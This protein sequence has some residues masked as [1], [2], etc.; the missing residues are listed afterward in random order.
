MA[1]SEES[2]PQTAFLR[3]EIPAIEWNRSPKERVVSMKKA[4]GILAF[5][6]LAVFLGLGGYTAWLFKARAQGHGAGGPPGMMGGIGPMPVVAADVVFVPMAD[7]IEAVGTASADKSATLTATVTEAVVATRFEEGQPVTAGQVMIQLDDAEEQATFE[8]ARKAY[9]RYAAL[10]K[11]SA[12]SVARRDQE[13]ARMDVAQ[14]RARDRQIVAPF[15]GVAGLRR[16]NVGDTVSAGTAM[17]TVDS[18]DPV[19]VRFSIPEIH[20]SAIAPDQTI[21]ARSAAWPGEVFQGTVSAVDSRID[22]VTRAVAVK[23]VIPNPDMKLRPGLLMTVSVLNNPRQALAVPEQALIETGTAQSVMAIG[24]DGKAEMRPVR[25]GVRQ[26][27]FVEI[28]SGLKEGE[29][30]II[31]GLQ[32][33]QPGMPVK[34]AQVKSIG[35][36]IKDSADF[37]IERKQEV[38]RGMQEDGRLPGA[39]P[40]PASESTSEPES[41]QPAASPGGGKAP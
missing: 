17:T 7:R 4:S 18:V 21:E 9:E 20:M 33:V 11:T 38:I 41:G 3:C 32:K 30:V 34:A 24:T 31:E 2:R 29:Q 12:A 40:V 37:A 1:N 16:V 5:V 8:E 14:A 28:L 22:P 10:A 35:E 15:D 25:P 27:G 36:S 13:K 6:L 23:A 39:E 19:K 26:A